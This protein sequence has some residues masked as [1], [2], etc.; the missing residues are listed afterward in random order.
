[1]KHLKKSGLS[2][3]LTLLAADREVFAPATVDGIRRFCRWDG[4]DPELGGEN[5]AFPP[6]DILF[7]KTEKMYSYRLGENAEIDDIESAPRRCIFGLRPCDVHSID[8]MDAVFFQKGY[9][10]SYYAARRENC[11]LVA[12]ACPGAGENCFCEA[13]GLDP[14]RA[15]TADILLTDAGES[16]AVAANTDA[17]RAELDRWA[18]LLA[19]GPDAAGDTHCRLAPPMDDKLPERLRALF[20]DEA[21]WTAASRACLGCGTCSFVCPTCYCFDINF[22]AKPGGEGTAF[23]CWD[24][25][26]F[27][28]YN[29][30]AGGYNARPTKR[31]RLRNRYLHKLVYF[32]ERYGMTLCAGC[33]RCIEKCPGHLD[34]TEFISR[35]AE[36]TR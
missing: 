1:M 25:C 33:G 27:S 22:A 21:L 13:M 23:R 4:F 12:L 28:D 35:A 7:P 17:G 6:K 18:P 36:V 31:E 32:R 29:Q 3:L 14:N 16:Y 26:M 10:D 24:S 8:C 15:P 20:D 34:I 11:L 5:A 2:A 9:V 19:D 30:N